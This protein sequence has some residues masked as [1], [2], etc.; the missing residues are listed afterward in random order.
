LRGD[1]TEQMVRVTVGEDHSAETLA[2][3]RFTQDANRGVRALKIPADAGPVMTISFRPAGSVRP[4][5]H[6]PASADTRPLGVALHRV[7]ITA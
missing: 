2:T 3:W 6:D 4:S 7:R 1:V 5:D